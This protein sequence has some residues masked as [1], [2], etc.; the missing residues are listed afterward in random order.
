[1]SKFFEDTIEQLRKNR[2]SKRMPVLFVGSGISSCGL[3]GLIV[4][5]FCFLS[6]DCFDA[7]DNFVVVKSLRS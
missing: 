3:A 4:S 7:L 2:L 6:L 5:L 1:M